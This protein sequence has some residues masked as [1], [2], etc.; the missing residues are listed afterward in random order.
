MCLLW[1]ILGIIKK[2][3]VRNRNA[4]EIFQIKTQLVY[5]VECWPLA[6][7]WQKS[8]WNFRRFRYI[9]PVVFPSPEATSQSAN[10]RKNVSGFGFDS[11]HL[12]IQY[13]ISGKID[14]SQVTEEIKGLAS[15][16]ARIWNSLCSGVCV[17]ARTCICVCDCSHS[18]LPAYLLFF[19]LFC[20]HFI[21]PSSKNSQH[22][23]LGLLLLQEGDLVKITRLVLIVSAHDCEGI[24]YSC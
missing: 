13:R 17:H 24:L 4:C 7:V 15:S 16:R 18:L 3:S 23:S 22:R 8:C 6:A 11:P 10:L 19:I 12:Q 14:S 1:K 2:K 21:P 5:I 9:S 20:F